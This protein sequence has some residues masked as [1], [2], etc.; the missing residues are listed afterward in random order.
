MRLFFLALAVL[1]NSMMIEYLETYTNYDRL[2]PYTWESGE[3]RELKLGKVFSGRDDIDCE[4]LAGQMIEHEFDLT[5]LK[6]NPLPSLRFPVRRPVEFKKLSNAYRTIFDDLQYFPIPEPKSAG[7]PDVVFEDG[8]MDARSYGGDRKHEGCD[9]MG[10]KRERGFY[11]VVSI[12]GGTV[13]KVGWLEQGGWRIGIRAPSGAYFYYAHLFRYDRQW[14]EG[15]QVTA[16]QLL[17]YMGDSGYGKTE[18]T[19]GNFEVHLHL[20]IYIKTD[21]YEEMAVNPYWVLRYLKK[22]RLKYDY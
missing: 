5:K 9:V 22:Y 18:G 12:T 3:F 2:S 20:G 15:D 17:G 6:S 21:H 11:P 1:F 19:V 4:E 13:E 7:T 10:N 8:W 14:K 16:G